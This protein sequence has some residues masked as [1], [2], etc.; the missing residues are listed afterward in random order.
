[1]AEA[2]LI[3]S[4]TPG[5]T[6]TSTGGQSNIVNITV[7]ATAGSTIGFSFNDVAFLEAITEGLGESANAKIQNSI[8]ISNGSGVQIDNFAP[9]ELN[10]NISSLN[11]MPADATYT[12]AITFFT[13]SFTFTQ[14]GNYTISLSSVAQAVVSTPAASPAPEPASMA[15]LGTG[16]FGLGLLGARCHRRQSV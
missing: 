9:P 11:G 6:I 1:V 10:T 12:N 4:L 13:H 7:S 15:L 8:Q 14:T 5:A 2:R 16:L 3:N